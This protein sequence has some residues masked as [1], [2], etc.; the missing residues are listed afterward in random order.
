MK[1]KKLNMRGFSHDI[2]LIMIVVLVAIAGVGYVVISHADPSTVAS[3]VRTPA[4]TSKNPS[5]C[6]IHPNG[7]ALPASTVRVPLHEYRK[8]K[9]GSTY[10]RDHVYSVAYN[11]KAMAALGYCRQGD[12]SFVYQAKAPRS[13]VPAGSVLLYQFYNSKTKH[14][15]Y[16]TTARLSGNSLAL[17]NGLAGSGW[18]SSGTAVAW[19]SSK[20]VASG[21]NQTR[22]IDQLFN[23]TVKSFYYTGDRVG[24]TASGQ[25]ANTLRPVSSDGAEAGA[26]I[27]SGYTP[28]GSSLS[29]QNVFHVWVKGNSPKSPSTKCSGDSESGPCDNGNDSGENDGGGSGSSSSGGEAED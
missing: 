13:K 5:G 8:L 3:A 1:V 29:V 26:I 19:V 17:L 22:G 4:A 9:S 21:A 25:I 15:V 14:H 2:V 28:V 23:P 18:S 12:H 16:A 27:R 10:V 7:P 6:T 11:D 24:L 20:S